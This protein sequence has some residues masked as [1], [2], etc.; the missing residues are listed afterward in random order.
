MSYQFLAAV[1]G[2]GIMAVGIGGIVLGF[3]YLWK[4][5][6]I[7]DGGTE[8]DFENMSARDSM[9]GKASIIAGV[10]VMAIGVDVWMIILDLFARL[11]AQ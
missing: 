4:K 3:A 1:L 11:P 10:G 7:E 5:R 2:L 6:S 8:G 9:I